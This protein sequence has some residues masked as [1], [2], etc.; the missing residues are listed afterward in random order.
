MAN[1]KINP[2]FRKKF[3]LSTLN[4]Q[5]SITIEE[6]IKKCNVSEI[7]IRRDLTELEEDGLLIKIRGGA[8]KSKIGNQLFSYDAK[9]NKNWQRKEKICQIASRYIENNDVIFI[10][11]GT[12]LFYLTKYIKRFESLIVITNSLPIVSE[13]LSFQ[14][15]KLILIGGEVT[16]ERKAMYGPIANTNISRYHADKAFIGADGISLR[17]GLSSYDEKEADITLQ[18]VENA[19][20]TFLLCDSSKIEK[21]SFIK[22]APFSKIDFLITNDDINKQ[23]LNEYRDSYINVVIE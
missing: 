7:T 5:E 23:Y 1:K 15:I 14:N 21:N 16:A 10:D 3:I 13:L 2:D 17:S 18:M 8:I 19:D 22:F 11:C 12:T 20:K 4:E 9:M 6:I